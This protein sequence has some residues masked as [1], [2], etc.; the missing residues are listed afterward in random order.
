MSFS[1]NIDLSDRDLEHFVAARNAAEEAARKHTETEIIDASCALLAEATK[2]Q[3][4]DFIA[5]RLAV[6]D[7]LIAMLRDEGWA[8]PAEDRKRVLA[9]LAYFVDPKDIIP[10]TVPVLGFLDDA[11]MIEL[12]TRELK[13]EIEAYDDF[14][15][16]RQ[17]EANRRELDPSNIGRAEF[18]DGRRDELIDR[19]HQR[20]D[21]ERSPGTGYGRTSGW[22]SG[23]TYQMGNSW[24][25]G[26]YS[27]R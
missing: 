20:R 25:P 4:P 3:V 18:L 19:M 24:R 6:L 5:Q 22:S 27:R 10:D 11:I 15:D 9:A 17:R 7:D 13:H 1:I 23:K 21:Q 12:C 8:M 2:V 16:Y 26:F 14:C